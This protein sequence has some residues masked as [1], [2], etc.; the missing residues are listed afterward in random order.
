MKQDANPFRWLSLPAL[1]L[2]A[3]SAG[4]QEITASSATSGNFYFTHLPRTYTHIC[5]QEFRL[6]VSLIQ[7]HLI[8][9]YIHVF[10]F[11]YLHIDGSRECKAALSAPVSDFPAEYQQALQGAFKINHSTLLLADLRPTSTLFCPYHI[12]SLLLFMNGSA[13]FIPYIRQLSQRICR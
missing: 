6:N 3:R 10:S 8:F 13:S 12:A 11:N 5:R 2:E 9:V 7:L 1:Q 4:V